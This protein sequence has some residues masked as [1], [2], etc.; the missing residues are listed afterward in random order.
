MVLMMSESPGSVMDRVHTLNTRLVYFFVYTFY[1]FFYPDQATK[2][3]KTIKIN[4][5][6]KITRATTE[7]VKR[8]QG[9]DS[10]KS[11]IKFIGHATFNP[12][13]LFFTLC[14]NCF[15]VA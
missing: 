3:K 13:S 5:R 14:S 9:K 4:I 2:E 6:I 1:L 7:V 11:T 12:Y 10:F 8:S 15:L